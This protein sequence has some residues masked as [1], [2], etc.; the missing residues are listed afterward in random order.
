MSNNT[1][2]NQTL[3]TEETQEKIEKP[4]ETEVTL[5]ETAATQAIKKPFLKRYPTL[6]KYTTV[7]ILSFIAGML[8][9]S[10]AQ[11][12]IHHNKH[13]QRGKNGH[14]T[15]LERPQAK[16]EQRSIPNQNIAIEAN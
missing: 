10:F 2:E 9:F 6:W 11:T 5:N 12:L 7:G 4:T 15:S 1:T 8:V 16:K 3:I 13:E 14:Q